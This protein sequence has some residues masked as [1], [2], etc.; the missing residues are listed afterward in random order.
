MQDQQA[1]YV[2]RM[3]LTPFPDNGVVKTIFQVEA[4]LAQLP[5]IGNQV[6]K[7]VGYEV[8]RSSMLRGL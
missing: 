4:Q 5:E 1:S 6:S 8:I 7:L 3:I 2:A